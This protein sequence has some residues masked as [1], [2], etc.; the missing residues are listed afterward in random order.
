MFVGTPMLNPTIV[1]LRRSTTAYAGHVVCQGAPTRWEGQA[2]IDWVVSNFRCGF[3]HKLNF[4]KFHFSD[5]I[6]IKTEL[7]IHEMVATGSL[8]TGPSWCKPA[9]MGREQ[10]VRL[11]D[12]CWEDLGIS[13][14]DLLPFET[15]LMLNW[16]GSFSISVF[17]KIWVV[18]KV[19]P[20][21]AKVHLG[22]CL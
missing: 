14:T 11:I 8:R 13:P 9:S 20:F 17:Q 22:R 2:E 19:S 3:T 7:K 1:L 6:P 16:I 21:L 10:W 15:D 18:S 5:H 4:S 12:Q